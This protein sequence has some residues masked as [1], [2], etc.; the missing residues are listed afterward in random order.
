MCESA[1]NSSRPNDSSAPGRPPPR[2]HRSARPCI[3][4]HI[5]DASRVD[6]DVGVEALALRG[7][8]TMSWSCWNESDAAATNTGSVDVE[9]ARGGTSR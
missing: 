6:V 5:T 1:M 2:I 7:L 3:V 9:C 4:V 8:A